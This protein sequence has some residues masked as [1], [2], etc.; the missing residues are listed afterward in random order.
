M[1]QSCNKKIKKNWI[2]LPNRLTNMCRFPTLHDT[3]KSIPISTHMSSP[4]HPSSNK[5]RSDSGDPLYK[6]QRGQISKANALL[7]TFSTLTVP[8]DMSRRALTLIKLQYRVHY[9]NYPNL[10]ALARRKL[11]NQVFVRTIRSDKR[12]PTSVLM[13][14]PQISIDTHVRIDHFY[15]GKFNSKVGSSL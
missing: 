3:A 14:K 4:R 10:D 7:S 5:T 2:I 13:N 8:I 11:L 6:Q 9:G 15:I 1:T 12:I